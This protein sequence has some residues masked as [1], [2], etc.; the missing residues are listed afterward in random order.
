MENNTLAV[1]VAVILMGFTAVAMI[2]TSEIKPLAHNGS[3]QF[4]ASFPD[5]HTTSDIGPEY[6]S[7]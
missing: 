5:Q 7:N 3:A 4:D 6:S 1:L 2:T